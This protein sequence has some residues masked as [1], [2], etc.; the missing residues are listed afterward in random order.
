MRQNTLT[1]KEMQAAA[2]LILSKTERRPKIGM[3]LGSGLNDLADSVQD[4]VSIPSSE[5]P[6]WP[7]STVESHKG[8]IVIGELEGKDV[9]VLQGRSHHYEGWTMEQVVFPVR[10]MSLLGIERLVLTNAA[11]GIHP[12]FQVTDLMLITDHI[13]FPGLAG[14]S[15]L[16]GGNLAD[17]GPR[18]VDM[19]R[20]YDWDLQ[21][22]AREAAEAESIKL[23]EGVYCF[24]GGPQFETPA[25]L[26][27]LKTIGGD[28]VGMSTAPA[29]VVANHCGIQVLG[30]STITNMANLNPTLTDKTDHEEVME[31]GIVVVP[32]L[33][34]LLKAIL[35]RLD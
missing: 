20:G 31:T 24:V 28:A 18:F 11:G 29:V 1:M 32:K 33:T 34:R 8:R 12:D 27:F 7:G 21:R 13:N 5:I 23:Q 17:F 30:I 2:D 35:S 3:V 26:R 25:E 22:I 14:N 9:L 10:V 16:R 4:A 19:T 15:P 6:N